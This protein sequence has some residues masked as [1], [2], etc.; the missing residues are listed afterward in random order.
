MDTCWMSE[1]PILTPTIPPSPDY[2]P[3]SPDYSPASDIESDLSEDSSSGHIPPLPVVLPF[4]S[5]DDDTTDSDTPDTSPLP[6]HGTPFTEITSSIQR[7]PLAVRHSVDHYSSDYFSLDDLAQDSSSDSSTE[8]SLDFHSDASSDSLSRHSLSDHSSLDLPSTFAGPSCKRRR[9]PITYIPA[10]PPVSEA[11]S[12]VRADLIPSPKRVRDCSYL[13]DVEVGPRETSLRDDVIARGSDEPHLEQDIDPEIQIEIVECFAYADALRDRG[14]DARVVVEAVDQDE[15]ETGVRGPIEVRVE[16]ITH[17]RFHDH[18]EA[19]PVHRVHVIEGVQREQGHRIVGVESA[20]TVLTKRV[21]ELEKDNRRLRGTA[22]SMTREEVEELVAR[23]V[24]E[25]MEAHEAARNFETLNENGEEQEGNNLTAYTQRF[26]ELILLCTLMVPDEEDKVERVMLQ[27]VP[28]IKVRMESNPRDNRGQQPPFKRQNTNGQNVTRAYI[29]GSNE[30]KGYVGFLPY[31]NKCR[32]HHE[33]LCTI[34]CENYMKI[35]YQTRDYRVTVTP[36]TYGATVGNHQ[37]I[38]C[39]EC[40][41]P[42]HFKKDYPKLRSQNRRNQTRN[43]TEDT[44]YAVELTDVR[45]YEMNIILRGCTLGLFGHPFNIDLMLIDLGSFDVIIG[46]DWLVKYHM[47]IICDEKVVRIPYGDEVYLAQVTSKKAEDK[48]KEKRLEDVPI[49][50]FL[51]HM[52]DSEGIH[53][54]PAKIKAIKDWASPKTPT[55]IHQFLGLVGYYR[56]FI[57]GFSK[58]ARPM[59]K[60]TLKS[61]KFDWGE[62]EEAAFQLLKQKVCSAP[63]LALPEGKGYNVR[64]SPTQGSREELYHTRPRAGCSSVCLED[65]KGLSVRYK[66]SLNKALGTRLDMSTTYHLETDGQSE[67]T[68]Q[69]LEDMLHSYVLDFGKGWDKH[70]PLVE[71]SYNNSY[72]T[73]IKAALFEAL[74]GRKCRLPIC[75]AESYANVRWKPLEF[76]VGDK[77]MLKVS[78]WKG[79][80]RFGKRGK[81]NPCYIG[82]FKILARVGTVAYRHELQDQLSRVH[83]T[84][85]VLKLKKCMADD[86]LAIPL[87]EIQ[88]DDKLNFIKEPIKIMNREVKR[89]K[90]SRI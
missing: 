83:S 29:T 85:H 74:Y 64:I 54:D 59:K 20:V 9:S 23:R 14:F 84:F 4:L 26:Q 1:T 19:I 35:G 60:L 18:T 6:T 7:S 40:G 58:I 75:W 49:V 12:P 53:V 51:G 82:P 72:H 27:G 21:S 16:R 34:R 36:N 46:M 17:P 28:R 71:F 65:V 79:V 57:K 89:L 66:K 56:R 33:G 45:I 32:L 41:R 73:S 5:S 78:P 67:R 90:Q 44:S 68:I 62:K 87:D 2:T 77:V 76:Q 11:L 3:A 52:I 81:L 25:E 48:S 80:I 30:R 43:K 13:A 88:V 50:K 63:I 37:G 55:E 70:L 39:Y 42:R 69:T 47:L 31:Y 15:I 24:F 86:P 61:I 38:G 22:A 10:L 8:A